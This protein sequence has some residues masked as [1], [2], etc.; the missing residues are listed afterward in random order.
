[1]DYIRETLMR[2]SL[3]ML[4]DDRI[5]EGSYDAFLAAVDSVE[6]SIREY[7]TGIEE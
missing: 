6:K 7:E 5:D 3:V 4:I 2:L 1:M